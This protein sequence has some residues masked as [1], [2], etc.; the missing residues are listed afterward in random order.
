MARYDI[1]YDRLVSSH[2]IHL[3]FHSTSSD[4]REF[5][6]PLGR[7]EENQHHEIFYFEDGN[8]HF[9]VRD[10]LDF[11]H[12]ALHDLKLKSVSQVA[13]RVYKV[14]RYFLIRESLFFEEMFAWLQTQAADS[15]YPQGQSDATAVP[16]DDVSQVEMDSLL[17]YLYFG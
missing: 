13:D 3:I 8:I 14:H 9:R 16:L 2:L 10:V 12:S 4:V 6:K 15:V 17:T 1:R 11:S 5:N 7:E